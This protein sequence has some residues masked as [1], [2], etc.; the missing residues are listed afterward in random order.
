[1]SQPVGIT[2]LQQHLRM[3]RIVH[4]AFCFTFVWFLVVG[5]WRGKEVPREMDGFFWS[6]CTVALLC[7]FAVL[8]LQSRVLDTANEALRVDASNKEAL[9]RHQVAIL[10]S[11]AL[12]EAVVLFGLVLRFAGM[13]FFKFLIFV[14]AGLALLIYSRPIDPSSP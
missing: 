8:Y 3:M 9:K 10:L 5:Y 11:F 1:M 4:I 2:P 13:E 6:I 12:C 14:L 7:G